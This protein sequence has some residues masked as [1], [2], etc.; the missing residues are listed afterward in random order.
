METGAEVAFCMELHEKGLVGPKELGEL[1]LKWGNASA[2]EALIRMIA[3]REGFG[4]VLAEGLQVTAGKIG[5]MASE[6]AIQINNMAL[7]AHDPRAYAS[8]ALTYATSARGPCHSS[9]FTFWFERASTFPELGIDKVLDRFQSEGKP[10]MVVNVQNA[11]TVWE[12]LTMCKFS[13]LGGVQL[14]DISHCL[15]DVTGWDFSIQ[16]LL[17]IGERCINLKRKLNAGW[18]LSRK[19]DTLPLRVLT[20]RVS[21]G[22]AG[23]HLPPLNIMLADYYEKRGW[24]KE[25][26]PLEETLRRLQI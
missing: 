17:E 24:S 15:K 6:Y 22:G 20:H 3:N 25:G 13:V 1:D 18:G 2:T 23:R 10:E 12:N 9:A 8:L 16:D 14:K 11:M 26:I 21:D 7:P 19:N 5:G 4:D